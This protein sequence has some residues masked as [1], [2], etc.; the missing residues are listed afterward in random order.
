MLLHVDG[1]A[2]EIFLNGNYFREP[3]REAR[4][5]CATLNALLLSM[6]TLHVSLKTN[7]IKIFRIHK[8]QIN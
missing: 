8:M 5:K 3:N 1:N 6:H 2:I 4:T 7:V